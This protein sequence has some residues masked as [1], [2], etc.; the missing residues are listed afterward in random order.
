M[1][2]GDID[3]S[4]F[5]LLELEEALAGINP[6]LYPNNY[7]NLRSTYEQR[8]AAVVAP[9]PSVAATAA[10]RDAHQEPATGLWG[11]F[12]GSRPML[13]IVGVGC[14]WW[15]HDV[16]SHTE[17]CLAGGKLIGAIVKSTCENFGQTVAAGIPFIIGVLSVALAVRP[18][19]RAGA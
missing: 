17:S 10:G 14:F 12:W 11:R 2:D 19:R 9:Q 15:A 18:G 5:T 6:Q 7:A 13:G 1:S 8:T 3:Y 16:F 4:K